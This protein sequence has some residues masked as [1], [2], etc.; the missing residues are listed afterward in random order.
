MAVKIDS[1]KLVP[2]EVTVGQSFTITITAVDVNWQV[3]KNEFQN[4]NEIK[5]DLSNW[6]SVL[7]YH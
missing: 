7:N 3:V 6:R 5:T 2:N 4:W 1:I